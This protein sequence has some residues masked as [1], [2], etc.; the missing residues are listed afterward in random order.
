MVAVSGSSRISRALE[1]LSNVSIFNCIDSVI[2]ELQK[3]ERTVHG[4]KVHYN[5]LPPLIR[6]ILLFYR[7][8]RH[9]PVITLVKISDT[10]LKNADRQSCFIQEYRRSHNQSPDAQKNCC[11]GSQSQQSVCNIKLQRDKTGTNQRDISS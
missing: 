7:H 9:L 4:S 11:H 2:A 6:R 10:V 8:I 5:Q 1:I 3:R